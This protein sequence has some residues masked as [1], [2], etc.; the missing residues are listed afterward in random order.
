LDGART[1]K[2]G[3]AHARFAHGTGTMSIM[4]IH[5]RPKQWITFLCVERTAISI[6]SFGLDLF[7]FSAFYGF[8]DDND[9]RQDGRD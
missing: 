4:A 5:L 1:V 2:N 8:V 7:A 6:A 3:N 9:Q